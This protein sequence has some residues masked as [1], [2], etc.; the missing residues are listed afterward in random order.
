MQEVT[1]IE[2]EAW[3]AGEFDDGVDYNRH[4]AGQVLRDWHRSI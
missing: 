2:P 4:I 1:F 3:Y